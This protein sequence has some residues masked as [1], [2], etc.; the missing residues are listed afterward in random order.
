MVLFNTKKVFD[1]PQTEGDFHNYLAL[2]GEA[3]GDRDMHCSDVIVKSL[4]TFSY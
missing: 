1:L 3:Q 4:F 2:V